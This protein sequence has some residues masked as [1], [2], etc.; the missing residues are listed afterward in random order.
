MD[1]KSKEFIPD[2]IEQL[3]LM[4]EGYQNKPDTAW[5]KTVFEFS[6]KAHEGQ[7]RRSGQA[8]ISHPLGV[9]GLLAHLKLDLETVATGLLHDTVEDTPVTLEDVRT[10]FGLPVAQMVDGVTKISKMKFRHTHEKQG[11]N[12]RK[13]I[14]AMGKDIRVVLVK[15]ADRLHNMRTLGHMPFEKQSRIA[16]ETLDIYAP[17]AS[18]L[19]INWLKVEL[20]DLSFRFS[21]PEAYYDLVQKIQKKKK[22]RESF[23]DD[24]VSVI[25]KIFKSQMKNQPEVYGRPKHL[26][27][28]YKKMENSGIEYEQVYDVL[29]FR[30]IVGTVSECYEALGHIHSLWK[31]IPG[32]FKDYIAMPKANNYQ[33]LHTTVIGPGGQRIE[34]QIRNNEMHLVAEQGIAAHWTYKEGGRKGSITAKAIEQFNWVR[35]IVSTHQDS[36]SADAFLEDFKSDLFDSEIYVFTPKGEV[37]EFPEGATPIDFAYSIHTEVGQRCTGAKVNGK[38]VPL[39]YQLKN[40]D[41]V[42]ILTSKTQVPSKDWLKNCV[43][44]RARTKIRSFV[45]EEERKKALTLGHSLVE[46]AFRKYGRSYNKAQKTE[47]L[48]A[49]MKERGCNSFEDLQAQVGYGKIVA[50]SLVEAAYPDAVAETPGAE[51]GDNI[52]TKVFKSLSK[53]TASKNS[54]VV[55]DGIDDIWVHFAKCCSPIPGDS[56]NGYVTRGRGIVIHTAHCQKALLMDSARQVDV[57]WH[58]KASVTSSRVVKLKIITTDNQGMLVRLSEVLHSRGINILNVQIRATKDRKAIC[59]FDLSIKNTSELS[60]VMQD[61]QSLP[62]VI[63]V[64]RVH[65]S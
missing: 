61:I 21:N 17:L 50:P 16:Q 22:E 40:G 44:S 8:Y 38:G 29:A 59:H 56:I 31:P 42:E 52:I 51:S 46:K 41:F 27:S 37:K 12:I 18:R 20:E 63:G 28:I 6:K 5:L 14:L 34:I 25:G 36:E 13:M 58:S 35:E 33:S 53:S 32:R 11:E 54:M 45:K 7:F 3:C 9:A 1:L 4:V 60:R 57:D 65:Q 10:H 48:L 49:F 64:N 15:L 62:D 19:G 30:I 55:V 26:F 24:T 47:G 43:T 2:T 39:K 23:I